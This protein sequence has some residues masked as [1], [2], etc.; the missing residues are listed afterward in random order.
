MGGDG[1]EARLELNLHMHVL[2]EPTGRRRTAEV[3]RAR[4]RSVM[5]FVVSLGSLAQCHH[6]PA[7]LG[8]DFL[9]LVLRPKPAPACL[10]GRK[11]V[12]DEVTCNAQLGA[13]AR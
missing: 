2:L 8:P 9:V 12:L 6:H 13:K 7:T 4:P 11:P 10:Q 1:R 3:C 5:V